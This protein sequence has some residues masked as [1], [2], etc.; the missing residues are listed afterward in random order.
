MHTKDL[1]CHFSLS[2]TGPIFNPDFTFGEIS[3]GRESERVGVQII[4]DT[5]R[6]FKNIMFDFINHSIDKTHICLQSEMEAEM[7]KKKKTC[8]Q[9]LITEC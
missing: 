9:F 8:E 4:I 6:N 3:T 7:R 1:L 2:L 5:Y